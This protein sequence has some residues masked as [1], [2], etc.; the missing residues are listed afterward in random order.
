MASRSIYPVSSQTFPFHAPLMSQIYVN[1]SSTLHMKLIQSCKYFF[2]KNPIVAV[3]QVNFYQNFCSLSNYQENINT[4]FT[5]NN[6][7][8]WITCNLFFDSYLYK[9]PRFLSAIFKTDYVFLQLYQQ[10]LKLSDLKEV[11][12]KGIYRSVSFRHFSIMDSENAEVPIDQIL[13]LFP[14]TL[15][16]CL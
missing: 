13:Q 7:K 16:F 14:E 9:W 1:R 10:T 15:C 4:N 3:H 11:A 6:V 5:K 2:V 12:D 8:V